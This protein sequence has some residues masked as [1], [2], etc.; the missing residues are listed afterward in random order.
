MSVFRRTRDAAN[1]LGLIVVDSPGF[2]GELDPTQHASAGEAQ[3]QTPQMQR[4]SG[5]HATHVWTIGSGESELQSASSARRRLAA[6]F[7][8]L[9]AAISARNGPCHRSSS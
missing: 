2:R 4:R 7:A 8:F 9:L 1:L 5:L 6:R 3:L